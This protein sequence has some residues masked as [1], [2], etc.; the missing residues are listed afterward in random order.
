MWKTAILSKARV[1][2][3]VAVILVSVAAVSAAVLVYRNTIFTVFQGASCPSTIPF[4]ANTMPPGTEYQAS[5]P[6]KVTICFTSQVQGQLG[7]DG[8]WLVPN[9]VLTNSGGFSACGSRLADCGGVNVSASPTRIFFSPQTVHVVA[10]IDIPVGST[11]GAY[12]VF[13]APGC[14]GAVLWLR[15]GESNRTIQSTSGPALACPLPTSL[16]VNVS[17]N[18]YAGMIPVSHNGTIIPLL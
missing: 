17:F 16:R 7:S 10:T 18:S 3:I 12:Y 4:Q 2:K 6:A 5:P 15:V 9:I 13:F 1:L 8:L 11:H 14:T